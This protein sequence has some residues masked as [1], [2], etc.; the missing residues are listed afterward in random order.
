MMIE[1]S[2]LESGFKILQKFL[3]TNGSAIARNVVYWTLSTAKALLKKIEKRGHWEL[4]IP[5]SV[6]QNSDSTCFRET[7]KP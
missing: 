1:V 4:M 6:F 7:A 2:Q 3:T 5:K